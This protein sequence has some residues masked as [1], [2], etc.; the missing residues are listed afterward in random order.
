MFA[1]FSTLALGASETT[2]TPGVAD[3]PSGAGEPYASATVP[4]GDDSAPGYTPVDDADDSVYDHTAYYESD[5]F[6]AMHKAREEAR[7]AMY[8]ILL[9]DIRTR[10]ED[11]VHEF[12]IP[13]KAE[14]L[15]AAAAGEDLGPAVD[16]GL[17]EDRRR[18]Q[19]SVKFDYAPNLYLVYRGPNNYVKRVPL[20]NWW[21]LPWKPS[22]ATKFLIH[23]FID[24]YDSAGQS[25]LAKAYIDDA[26]FQ[27]NVVQ[28]DWNNYNGLFQD[29]FSW[30]TDHHWN[31]YTNA[32]ENTI[33]VALT[34][35]YYLYHYMGYYYALPFAKFHCVGHSLGAQMCGIIGW[36]IDWFYGERFGR[37][38]GLDPAGP[39]WVDDVY[40]EWCLRREDADF[41]DVIHSNGHFFR[42][43]LGFV[44]SNHYGNLRP[45]GDADYYPEGGVS[46]PQ[47]GYLIGGGSWMPFSG[48]A[49]SHSMAVRYMTET[50]KGLAYRGKL[51]T[52]TIEQCSDGTHLDANQVSLMGNYARLRYEHGEITPTRWTSNP[53]RAYYVSANAN[54]WGSSGWGVPGTNV[55]CPNTLGCTGHYEFRDCDDDGVLDHT[56]KTGNDFLIVSSADN[57][58]H[59]RSSCKK[60]L[61]DEHYRIPDIDDYTHEGWEFKFAFPI[62][63]DLDYVKAQAGYFADQGWGNSKGWVRLA[64]RDQHWNEVASLIILSLAPHNDQHLDAYSEHSYARAPL[65]NSVAYASLETHVGGGGGHSL[66]IRDFQVDFMYKCEGSAAKGRSEQWQTGGPYSNWMPR[67]TLGCDVVETDNGNHAYR[68]D[69]SRS[70]LSQYT[71]SSNGVINFEVK[72]S[73]DVHLFLGDAGTTGYEIVISGWANQGSAIRWGIAAGNRVWVWT[74]GY[75]SPTEWR[76]FWISWDASTL[77]VG[78]PGE[79][80]FMSTPRVETT[81]LGQ[82]MKVSTGYG[83]DGEFRFCDE[84]T[85]GTYFT[86]WQ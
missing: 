17:G 28:L 1:L 12:E 54:N 51:C 77:S 72:A 57:C 56:C 85:T 11:G 25:G 50:V 66:H 69:F 18:Y 26:N 2:T 37:I 59:R 10:G 40:A 63:S 45:M 9:N 39:A 74:V 7:E 47:C 67:L 6:K 79:A 4:L 33:D 42:G 76:K 27:G 38:T 34:V 8:D 68:G 81:Y 30:F 52:G 16:S 55:V 64:F 32:V 35:A 29:S 23:G 44:M 65:P 46:Q 41:V 48:M 14:E 49:C 80:A 19:G 58:I 22:K 83:S 71:T 24:N 73:N 84:R 75:L 21:D 60:H 5:E 82:Y 3:V 36:A 86:N 43:P 53:T 70:I 15:A 31:G 13:T 61:C 78:R 62:Y 20:T